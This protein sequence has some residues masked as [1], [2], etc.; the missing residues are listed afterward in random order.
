MKKLLI[1]ALTIALLALMAPTI[2]D[3]A[4]A[5]V[6]ST[7]VNG[8]QVYYQKPY[9]QRWIDAIGVDV[10]KYTQ[11]FSALA[12]DDTTNDP[13]EWTW[14]PTEGGA[15]TTEGVITGVAGGEFLVTTAANENDGVNMQLKGASFYLAEGKPLYFGIKIKISDA[16]ESDLF[17][18]VGAVDTDWL[19]G[20]PDGIYFEKLDDGTGVSA[21]TEDASETQTDGVAVMDTSYHIYEF[22]YD[23]VFT[24]AATAGTV[25]FWIDGTQV[26]QHTT[27]ANITTDTAITPT[28]EYLTGTGGVDTFSIDWL[29]IIHPR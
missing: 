29:Y 10:V 21:V 27:A 9:R 25:T 26:A 1:L 2:A 5:N 6:G 11:D 17:L 8:A 24:T 18:G 23:G 20:L 12:V 7:W 13:T 4:V 16:T 15:G 28:I 19:G 14:S 3:A 22:Y